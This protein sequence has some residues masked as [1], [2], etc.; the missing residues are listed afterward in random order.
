MFLGPK[1]THISLEMNDSNARKPKFIWE[2][3]CKITLYY[4]VVNNLPLVG[5]EIGRDSSRNGVIYLCVCM[6][7]VMSDSFF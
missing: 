4:I 2:T 3:Q 5:K 6:H 7:S 1:Q